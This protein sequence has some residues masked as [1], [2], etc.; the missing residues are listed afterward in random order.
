MVLD[1]LAKGVSVGKE[2][3]KDKAEGCSD[4]DKEKCIAT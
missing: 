3:R 1:R 4:S 2:E